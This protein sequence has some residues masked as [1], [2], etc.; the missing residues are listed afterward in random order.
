MFGHRQRQVDQAADY[1]TRWARTWQPAIGA[2]PDTLPRLARLATGTDHPQRLH[3]ALAAHAHHLAERA[4]PQRPDAHQAITRA[5]AV[6]DRAHDTYLH[7]AETYD[8]RLGRL[9]SPQMLRHARRELRDL[10]PLAELAR[11]GLDRTR[12]DLNALSA[13]PAIR[14]AGTDLLDH[15]RRRW[16]I[17][18]HMLAV[19]E[20]PRA[21]AR[22]VPGPRVPPHP[23]PR[24]PV[25]R[26]LA[27]TGG[28]GTTP[29]KIFKRS[30]P[31]RGSKS[32][33]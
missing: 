29:G 19:T 23:G 25:P 18:H 14:A 9:A 7:A 26:H 11:S 24:R 13:E 2:L 17:N 16:A 15:E 12:A 28:A 4:H 3:D 20:T 31:E 27:L 30:W 6:R 5:E 8:T 10:Q 22:A 1:L 33:F 32:R 21:R